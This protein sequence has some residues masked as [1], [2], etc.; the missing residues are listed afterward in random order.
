MASRS[1]EASCAIS[2]SSGESSSTA[3]GRLGVGQLSTLVT[4]I[5]V[6]KPRARNQPERPH[7]R[8]D[9]LATVPPDEAVPPEAVAAQMLTV[10]AR[11]VV[12]LGTVAF[13]VSFLALL[14]A[15]SWLGSHHHRVWLWTALVGALLGIISLPLVSRHKGLGR[16]G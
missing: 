12:L 8:R 10:D 9:S 13:A 11:R 6:A 3:T 7:R 15:W 14:P 2:A 4:T 5:T 16:L 1:A